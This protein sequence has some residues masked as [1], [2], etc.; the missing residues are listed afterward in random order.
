MLSDKPPI[1]ATFD[2][3]DEDEKLCVSVLRFD[4]QAAT[5]ELARRPIFVPFNGPNENCR[6][7]D[8]VFCIYD[9]DMPTYFSFYELDECWRVVECHQFWWSSSNLQWPSDKM[10]H[11]ACS[12]AWFYDRTQTSRSLDPMKRIQ[13]IERDEPKIRECSLEPLPKQLAVLEA[14]AASETNN[15]HVSWCALGEFYVFLSLF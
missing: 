3:I 10:M 6:L 15:E 1:I 9:L 5:F 7:I 14:W 12:R 2:T 11:F 13:Y 4:M 8:R